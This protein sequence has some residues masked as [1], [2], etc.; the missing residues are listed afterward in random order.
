MQT[1]QLI[2][3]N[4]LF[5][6]TK[7]VIDIAKL[8]QNLINGGWE[9]LYIETKLETFVLIR[10]KSIGSLQLICFHVLTDE[11]LYIIYDVM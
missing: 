11:L 5:D 3:I 9:Y 6:R 4:G 2:D 7:D 8:K 1:V 10:C